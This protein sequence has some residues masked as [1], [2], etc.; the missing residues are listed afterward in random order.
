MGEGVSNLIT[1]GYSD[2]S[3]NETVIDYGIPE[4]EN[5]AK[6]TT[7]KAAK[8]EVLRYHGTIDLLVTGAAGNPSVPNIL[9]VEIDALV[10]ASGTLKDIQ[11]VGGKFR[12]V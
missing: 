2:E 6:A 1:F 8:K 10:N 4:E 11:L 3:L 7:K 9:E 12:R 5:M